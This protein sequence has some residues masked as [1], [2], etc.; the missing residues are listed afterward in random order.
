[1]MGTDHGHA[2]LYG[3][4]QAQDGE[5]RPDLRLVQRL[6]GFPRCRSQSLEGCSAASGQADQPKG[7]DD[8][9]STRTSYLIYLVAMVV[10]ALDVF[11][12]RALPY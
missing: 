6:V 9:M 12:W 7:G 3:A 10:V 11:V 8:G 5:T 2:N 4:H 1:M